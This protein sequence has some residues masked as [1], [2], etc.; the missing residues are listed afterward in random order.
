[1]AKLTTAVLLLAL[2]ACSY[3]PRTG[4]RR[5]SNVLTVA[6]INELALTTAYE[7]VQRLRPQWLTQRASPSVRSDPTEPTGIA[8]EGRA[9]PTVY[10][11]G[12]RVG[13]LEVLREMSIEDV[14]EMRFLSPRDA[15]NRFG[16]GHTTGAILVTTPR[17]GRP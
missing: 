1:M 5:S 17:P 7:A 8:V 10:I 2:T 14:G 9:E 12:V 16:T 15:T 3:S 6:E 4:P 13:H 11:D